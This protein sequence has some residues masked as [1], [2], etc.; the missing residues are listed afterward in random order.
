MNKQYPKQST[1]TAAVQAALAI[2]PEIQGH[3]ADESKG[4]RTLKPAKK[5]LLNKATAAR[6]LIFTNKAVA[7]QA[8]ADAMGN[9]YTCYVTG[10]TPIDKI[11]KTLAIF[12]QNYGAFAD[13]NQ[14]ARRKRKGLGNVMSVFFWRKEDRVIWWLLST[15]PEMGPHLIHS[16]DRLKNAVL[17]QER[18]EIDG[19]ELVRVPKPGT[20]VSKLTWRMRDQTYQDFRDYVIDTVRSRSHGSMHNMLYQLW[21]MP[22]FSGIRSQTGKLV[23]L[24][25]AELKRAGIKDAPQPPRKLRY[26]RRIPHE[27]LTAREIL[28]KVRN[29]LD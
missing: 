25:R 11:E 10:S 27:G 26:L 4:E 5:K 23:A 8:L 29:E 13:R 16:S 21:S 22:G 2:G 12:G 9:G 24:Y 6:P 19:Y 28:N 7:M 14:R 18:F 1:L 15:P 17:P 20:S 3:E